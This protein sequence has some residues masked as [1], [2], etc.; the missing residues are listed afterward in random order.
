M[1]NL[2]YV[3]ILK[4]SNGAYYTGYTTDIQRRYEEHCQGS[5]KCK[6][7]RSFPPTQLL[8]CWEVRGPLSLALQ[9]EKAIKRLSKTNKQKLIAKPTCASEL[10]AVGSHEVIYRSLSSAR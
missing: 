10:I 3:Y 4:C 8:A 7:T 1:S 6:Y 2:F 5:D 9:L